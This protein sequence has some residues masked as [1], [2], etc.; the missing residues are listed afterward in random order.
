MV[1]QCDEMI[2][3][4][5]HT[6]SAWWFFFFVTHYDTEYPMTKRDSALLNLGD[7]NFTG[8]KIGRKHTN[9]F[10]LRACL[11]MKRVQK[12]TSQSLCSSA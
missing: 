1:F 8:N 11:N 5:I 12:N 3:M 6:V 9:I 4:R 7:S 2:I 10:P